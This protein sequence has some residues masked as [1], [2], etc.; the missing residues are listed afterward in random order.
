[1]VRFLQSAFK[2]GYSE[3]DIVAVLDNPLCVAEKVTRSGEHGISILGLSTSTGDII[4][5]MGK[6]DRETGETV[7][8]NTQ[9]APRGTVRIYREF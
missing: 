7:V 4:E 5:V 6:H 3:E 1:M 9:K 8:F 2:H